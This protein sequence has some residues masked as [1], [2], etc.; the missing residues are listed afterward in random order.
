MT[1][2]S[3]VSPDTAIVIAAGGLGER[4]GDPNGKQFVSLCGRP[5]TAWSL[6]ACDAAPS[7]GQIVLVCSQDRRQ[8]MQEQVVEPLGLSTP[9]VFA[10]AGERRQDSCL[11]GLLAADTDRFSIVGF[12]DAARPLIEAVDIE[13]ALALLRDDPELDGALIAQPAVDTLKECDGDLVRRTPPR[14]SLWAAQT[15]Q[16]LR[17]PIALKSY[18][19]A[20]DD[21]FSGTDDV[22]LAERYGARVRCVPTG[23]SNLKVTIHDDLV[24]AAALLSARQREHEAADSATSGVAVADGGARCSG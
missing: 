9:I 3:P 24:L 13:A 20:R 12:H 1:G 21:G 16:F 23:K 4:F 15:P 5:L 11:S 17:T 7:V 19:G 6:L 2:T 14:A 22:S 8:R 18:L 10:E